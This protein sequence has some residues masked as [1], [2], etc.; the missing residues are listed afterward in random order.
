[1]RRWLLSCCLKSDR[2]TSISNFENPR[3]NG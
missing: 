2:R 1:M 3:V